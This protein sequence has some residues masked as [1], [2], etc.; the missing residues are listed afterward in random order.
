MLECLIWRRED[1]SGL[2][3]TSFFEYLKG[4]TVE[5]R[6]DVVGLGLASAKEWNFQGGI[7]WLDISHSFPKMELA[8]Q[9]KV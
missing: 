2:Y 8:A 7:L 3:L 4:C 6:L 5:E 9:K 1:S